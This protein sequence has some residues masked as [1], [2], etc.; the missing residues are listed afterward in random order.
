MFLSLHALVRTPD[1]LVCHPIITCLPLCTHYQVSLQTI[2][3]RVSVLS[4]ICLFLISSACCIIS[5][6][7]FWPLRSGV[8]F[9]VSGGFSNTSQVGASV[10][11]HTRYPSLK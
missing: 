3:L 6:L 1:T 5:R 10:G 9:L 2:P 8:R 11:H 7:P 4:C